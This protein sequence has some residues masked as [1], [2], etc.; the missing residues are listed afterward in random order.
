VSNVID[1]LER[2]GR[3]ARLRDAEPVE[4][5]QAMSDAQLEPTVRTAI[6]DGDQETLERLLGANRNVCCLV[7]PAREDEEEEEETEDDDLDD[8]DDDDEEEEEDE[9]EEHEDEDDEDLDDED[10]EEE[11]VKSRNRA[12]RRVATAS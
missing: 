11:S 10:D 1:F 3:N 8:D 5:E 12:V 9:D 4:L 6:L 7:A 2:L